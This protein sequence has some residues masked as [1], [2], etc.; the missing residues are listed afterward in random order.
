LQ[1][2]YADLGSGMGSLP[3]AE[4]A[5]EQVLSL[6]LYP[7]LPPQTI[8]EVARAVKKAIAPRQQTS[9]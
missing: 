2:A 7:E 3:Q 9:A 5:S 4:A 8:A 6:P 1:P